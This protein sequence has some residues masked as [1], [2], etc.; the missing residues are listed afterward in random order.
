[1]KVYKLKLLNGVNTEETEVNA[2]AHTFDNGMILFWTKNSAEEWAM[3]AA[4]PTTR[5][6]ITYY[7]EVPQFDADIKAVKSLS[8]MGTKKGKK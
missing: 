6:A 3:V 2:E 7:D 4:Y 8:T 1:M 5:T